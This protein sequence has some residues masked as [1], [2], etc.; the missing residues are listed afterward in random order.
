MLSHIIVTATSTSRRMLSLLWLFV[1]ILLGKPS[2]FMVAGRGDSSNNH[3]QHSSIAEAHSY[4][5]IV[6]PDDKQAIDNETCHPPL[7]GGNSSVPCKSLDYVFQQFHSLDSVLFYLA[8]PNSLYPLQNVTTF[9]DVSIISIVGNDTMNTPAV[10]QCGPHA[11]LSFLH[12]SSIEINYVRFFN[13]GAPQNST[14]RDFTKPRILR[15]LMINVSLYFYNCTDVNMYHTEVVN[16]SQATGVVMYDTNGLIQVDS[17]LFIN[18]RAD[19][20]TP[21]GGAFAVEFTYC[22]PGDT[23]TTSCPSDYT[24]Y[25]PGYR[26]SDV[27]TEYRFT[28][29]LFQWN[30]AR[31]Q[32]FT[33]SAG[34]LIFA[35]LNNHTGVGRGGG[36]A[37]YFK[38]VAVNKSVSISNCHFVHN[39]AVW[40]GGVLV[41]MDD[42][43]INNSV[44]MSN[45]NFTE[46]HAFFH[47]D[48]GTGG[49]GLRVATSV[50][51]WNDNYK[52]QNYTRNELV[53]DHCN[54]TGNKAIEGG[55]VS[56]SVARQGLSHPSQVTHLLVSDCKFKTNRAQL[57]AAVTATSYPIFSEGFT[58]PL[59]FHTCEFTN[60][61][62]VNHLYERN[63][64][65]P[66]R[67]HPSGIGAIYVNQVAVTF[68][69]LNSFNSNRGSALAVVGAQ[70]DFRG[71]TALFYNNSGSSG[72]G[73]ALLGASSVLIGPNTTIYFTENY[74]SLHGGAIY[75]RYISKEDLKSSVN[76]FIR[77]SDP[78]VGPFQ[79]KGVKI[80]FHDNKAEQ[81][82]NSIYS[83]A[84]L[85]CSWGVPST[86]EYNSIFCNEDAWIFYNS[87]CNNEIYTEPRRINFRPNSSHI[88]EVFPGHGLVL[89]LDAFDDFDHN[90]T[91]DAVYATNIDDAFAQVE[92]RYTYVAHNFV[93]ITGKPGE[94]VSMSMHTAGSRTT[95]IKV[96]LSI[97]NCPPGFVE[98]VP[99]GTEMINASNNDSGAGYDSDVSKNITCTCLE[100]DTFRGNLRCLYYEFH[101]QIHNRYWIGLPPEWYHSDDNST[102]LLMGLVPQYYATKALY[103]DEFVDLPQN[104]SSMDNTICGGGNRNG[105]LCG[106]CLSGYGV[107]INSPKFVCAL[108]NNTSL[109]QKVGYLSAY[110]ALTYLPILGLFFAI[111]IFNFKLTSSAAVSFVLFAQMIGSG[112]FSLTA[113]EALYVKNDNIARMEQAITA[114]YGIF[115]LNSLSFLMQPFCV[116]ESLTTLNVLT[117]EYATAAFPLLMIAAIY[118]LYRCKSLQCRCYRSRSQRLRGADPSS[119]TTI[120]SAAD[121]LRDPK[122]PKNTL[123]HAF[124][125]FLFLSYTKFSLASMFTMSIT[126]L[127][128]STGDSKGTNIIYFAGHLRFSD[129]EY[130]VPY[131][132][133]AILVLIFIVILPPLFLLG[134]IQFVDWL[135][136]K[137][138]FR[139]LQRVWPSIKVHTFLDT[140]QG[141]YK[142]NRRFF[143]GVYFLF[144]LAVFL[145]YSF[146]RTILS[147]YIFQ[148][149]AVMVLIVLVALLRPYT[150]DFYNYLDV[151]I[152]FNLGTLNALAIYIVSNKSFSFPVDLYIVAC[153][154]VWLPFVYIIC[155]AVWNRTHKRAWYN[156]LKQKVLHLLKPL[157][158]ITQEDTERKRL[159]NNP[160]NQGTFA[161]RSLEDSVNFI[162]DDPDEGLFQ[163]AT[164]KNRYARS[165]PS[166]TPV[167][168]TVVSVSDDTNNSDKQDSGTSTGG[169]S[170]SGL[171]SNDS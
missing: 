147:Q 144:R 161:G 121:G 170:R 69:F 171:H 72:G 124:V 154:L 129:Q 40:G 81:L 80:N 125:A 120:N 137:R 84:I 169:S 35:S 27:A 9:K 151:L 111:I 167:S 117:I 19:E 25:D 64:D 37:V 76:C 136:D 153:I 79:W 141:F 83:T 127:F 65:D 13:C 68:S 51:F 134:P 63:Q 75:N 11:G 54:F 168:T 152:L 114:V 88:V 103:G 38:G 160:Q 148:Q 107:A 98:S 133:V 56:F 31:G 58:P 91:N 78:F 156:T 155:Y 85:P 82:G 60:N 135:I 105:T 62:I 106:R 128:D 140:F 42:N 18:N 39:G 33:N 87:D 142:P 165:I 164:K 73:L 131:G 74:A 59:I 5:I 23:N 116:S 28:S 97:Q 104:I 20:G 57:G 115:N 139:W 95:Y 94:N 49:G 100:S 145:D 102:S 66:L 48:F 10:I 163:R 45:C 52:L 1:I 138:G 118:L 67:S 34:N 16:S 96:E 122:K 4:V 24:T 150:R 55:A 77:Y 157:I 61:Y 162:G 30:V 29:C 14:S 36:L 53:V 89:Q 166:G 99:Y 15:M 22:N 46:N 32:D 93:G 8:S 143:S 44:L 110:L 112:V 123:I 130:L 126:E 7:G 92:P 41:E 2:T 17:C 26:K 90:V 12:S 50:Y 132:I 108:C 149:V 158:M 43:T 3:G 47:D 119:S 86:N 21:G 70:V 113:G 159:I 6:D 146:S 101:S 71:A 109:P